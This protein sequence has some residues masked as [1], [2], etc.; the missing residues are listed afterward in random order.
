MAEYVNQKQAVTNLQTY[1]RR[2]SFDSLGASA[3][4][5]DGIFDTATRDALKNFQKSVGLEPTGVADK[6][7][8][9]A[10]FNAYKRATE[11]ER[12]AEALYLFPEAPSDYAVSLGERLML[13]NVLQLLMIELR[14]AYD[15]FE[16]VNESGV[17][18]EATEAAIRN[19]QRINMLPETGKVDATTYNRIVREYM[20]IGRQSQ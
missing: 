2:L 10:L 1:L 20:N 18:D 4:P 6:T 17:Y 7:T 14:V 12:A 3:V 8:W 11:V 15:I 19:F 13:V 5:I 9:D 16:N